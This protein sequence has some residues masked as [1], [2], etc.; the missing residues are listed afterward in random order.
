MPLEELPVLLGES[1][2]VGTQPLDLPTQVGRLPPE[3]IGRGP[4][5]AKVA[6]AVRAAMA[7]AGIDDPADVHYVQTKTP[8]LTIHT[9]R[10]AESRGDWT[11][12]V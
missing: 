6:D 9:I 4:M 5:I 8:L 10:D 11:S 12:V 7:R 3:E 2:A 1:F